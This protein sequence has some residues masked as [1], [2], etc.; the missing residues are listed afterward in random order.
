MRHLNNLLVI[1]VLAM[2]AFAPPALA[3]PQAGDR[4][5]AR[6]ASLPKVRAAFAAIDADA[7]RALREMV[8]LTEIPAPPFGEEKRA[9]R[10]AAMLREAGLRDVSIDAVG[11]VIARRPGRGGGPNVALIAHI[12]TVFPIE[13]DVTVKIEG[14][15]YRAPGIGDNSR[16]LV[17]VLSLARAMQTTR[18]ETRGDVLFVGS[19]GEEGLGDLRGVRHLFREGGPKIDVALAID[20]GDLTRVVN[21]GVGSLRYRLAINGPG[22]HSFGAFGLANPHHA[23][24]RILAHF[25][26]AAEPLTRAGPKATYNVGRLGGGTSIN[27]IPTE[28]WAEIDL[29]SADPAALQALDAAL[30][31]AIA[32]GLEEENAQRREGAALTANN[33]RVGA[34]PAGTLQETAPLAL[35]VRAAMAHFGV[36]PVFEPASTDA[37]IPMSQGIPAL[38]LGRGG[39]SGRV[40]APDEYWRNVDAERAIKIGL[41]V[42]LAQA[43]IAR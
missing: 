31:Q 23:M 33:Q 4:A 40:H 41:L 28:S 32:K 21:A 8:E 5:I 43:G 25:D 22:G 6:A 11:N 29:R 30:T 36:T 13:T 9:V 37:N 42:T 39:E 18:L 2:G 35:T 12:D 27:T 24:A 20:G 15:T 16:G 14:D 34:R 19:V 1:F 17:Y 38:T 7:P 26:A 3:Q 10:F